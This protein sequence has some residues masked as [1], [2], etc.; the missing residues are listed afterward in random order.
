MNKNILIK[1]PHTY[2]FTLLG[3][4]LVINK[5][6]NKYKRRFY[7]KSTVDSRNKQELLKYNIP[8]IKESRK[9]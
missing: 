7:S 2:P 9:V 5:K 8:K 4:T 3:K 6:V 1:Y